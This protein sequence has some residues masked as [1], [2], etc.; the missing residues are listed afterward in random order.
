MRAIVTGL[1]GLGKTTFGCA[2]AE[3]HDVEVISADAFRFRPGTWSKVNLAEFT[4]SVNAAVD[5]AIAE[6]GG[7][8][9]ESSYLDVHDAEDARGVVIRA[10]L[11]ERDAQLFILQ[12]SKKEVVAGILDRSF[13]RYAGELPQGAAHETPD[14]VAQLLIKVSDNFEAINNALVALAKAHVCVNGTLADVCAAS[15]IAAPF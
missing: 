2:L 3:K 6:T 15:E 13:R 7:F 10:L 11:R 8:V 5:K 14:T 1:P 12:G 9:F 4:A